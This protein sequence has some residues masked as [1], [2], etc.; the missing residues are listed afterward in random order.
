MSAPTTATP[1]TIERYRAIRDEEVAKL[2]S[3]RGN[4]YADAVEI[5]NTL[6]DSDDFIPFLTLPAYGYL[7]GVKA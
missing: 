2:D 3:P 4:R 7:D 6:I 5:L 1:V